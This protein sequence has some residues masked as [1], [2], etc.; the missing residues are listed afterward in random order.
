VEIP[1]DL[2]LEGKRFKEELPA[3]GEEASILFVALNIGRCS[4][5]LLS[6]L[7]TMR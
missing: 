3:A 5:R 4:G 1:T 6:F 2:A 7:A